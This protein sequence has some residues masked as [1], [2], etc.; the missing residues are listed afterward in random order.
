M[1]SS[2]PFLRIAKQFNADYGQVLAYAELVFQNRF[3]WLN[4]FAKDDFWQIQ[5]EALLD[6]AVKL[7]I[8]AAV[9]D[10]KDRRK[11][12]REAHLK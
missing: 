10:E 8:I 4:F 7:A 9:N 11:K 5:A 1:S 3:D 6:D 12:V 2:Y